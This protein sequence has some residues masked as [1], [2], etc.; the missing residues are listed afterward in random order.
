VW[1]KIAADVRP[2]PDSNFLVQISPNILDFNTIGLSENSEMEVVIRNITTTDLGIKIVDMPY[3]FV[4][5]E[6]SSKVAKPSEEIKLKVKLK[7]EA[8]KAS[9]TK[10][11][12][13]QLGDQ[14][15]NRFTIPVRK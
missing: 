10:S 11:I 15:R 2:K 13:L 9:L 3:E 5:G 7:R 6:L 12:T 4:E 14:N 1:V 8:K